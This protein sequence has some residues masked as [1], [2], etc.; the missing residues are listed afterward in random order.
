MSVSTPILTTSSDTCAMAA[1][2]SRVAAKGIAAMAAAT[3]SPNLVGFTL[4][5]P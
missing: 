5:L 3:G 2:G 1:L 4:V